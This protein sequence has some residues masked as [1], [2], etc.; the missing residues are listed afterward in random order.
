M[1]HSALNVD[2][3]HTV[4]DNLIQSDI[5][6]RALRIGV[7]C[8]IAKE[9]HF[10]PQTEKVYCNT[11]NKRIRRIFGSHLGIY[12]DDNEL[13]NAL[14]RDPEAFF[15]QVYG[16]RGGNGAGDGFRY[17]GRGFNQLT[18]RDNYRAYSYDEVNLERCPALL[19]RV[20]V[21]AHVCVAFFESAMKRHAT[22]LQRRFEVHDLNEIDDVSTGILVA[23][24]INAGIGK[25]PESAVVQT[26]WQSARRFQPELTSSYD[27]YMRTNAVHLTG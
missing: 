5:T 17:R 10:R 22:R 1:T 2:A 13:L 19:N 25:K 24:N 27:A 7:L 20:D 12:R 9:S 16:H 23:C 8:C 15:N 3:M 6:G 4:I 18:F 11:S 26:A 21:A 14:K